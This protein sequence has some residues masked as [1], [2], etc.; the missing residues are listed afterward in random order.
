MRLGDFISL[1][2]VDGT[3]IYYSTGPGGFVG[4]LVGDQIVRVVLDSTIQGELEAGEEPTT[5]E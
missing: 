2:G 5:A 4:L 1:G 3:V